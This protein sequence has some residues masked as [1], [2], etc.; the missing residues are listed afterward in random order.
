MASADNVATTSKA[1]STLPTL[2][3]AVSCVAIAGK[4]A[5]NGRVLLASEDNA[6]VLVKSLAASKI[7]VASADNVAVTL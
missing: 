1:A 6:T 5:S 3:T 7:V 4:L 2:P